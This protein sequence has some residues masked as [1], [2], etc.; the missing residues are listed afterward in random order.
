MHR[1]KC[2]QFVSTISVRLRSVGTSLP[3]CFARVVPSFHV[4]ILRICHRDLSAKHF[5]PTLYSHL[6]NK[7][8]WTKTSSSFN[9]T[10][11]SNII[12]LT[13]QQLAEYSSCEFSGPMDRRSISFHCPILSFAFPQNCAT[14]AL[15]INIVWRQWSKQPQ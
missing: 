4:T 3:V 11:F 8:V 5:F 10:K 7:L 13:R 14:C 12:E 6:D 1:Q 15:D 9:S 2:C